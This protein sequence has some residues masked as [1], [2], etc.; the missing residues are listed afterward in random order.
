M[1]LLEPVS[2]QTEI[3][4]SFCLRLIFDP[5]HPTSVLYNQISFQAMSRNFFI[6]IPVESIHF[7]N[8]GPSSNLHVTTAEGSIRQNVDQSLVILPDGELQG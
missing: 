5:M 7:Q 1:G 6:V 8:P 2:L 4:S 3:A